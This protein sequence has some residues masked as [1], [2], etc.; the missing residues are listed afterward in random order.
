V[1][2]LFSKNLKTQSQTHNILGTGGI[3]ATMKLFVVGLAKS[4]GAKHSV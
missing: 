4:C 1:A 2:F 3:V